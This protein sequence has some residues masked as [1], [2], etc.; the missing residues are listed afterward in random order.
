ML[1]ISGEPG[2][3]VGKIVVNDPIREFSGY[4]DKKATS[5]KI[6]TDVFKKGDS[7]FLSGDLLVMDADGYLYF[8][9]RT[10]GWLLDS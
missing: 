8:K 10:G 2:E 7:A 5:K 1:H 4:A 6:I 3:F 9:D